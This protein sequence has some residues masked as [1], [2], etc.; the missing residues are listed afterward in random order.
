LRGEAGKQPVAPLVEFFRDGVV[1]GENVIVGS[2]VVICLIQV[3]RLLLAIFYH[4]RLI[5][6]NSQKSYGCDVQDWSALHL[7]C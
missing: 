2:A 7:L 4:Y 1:G 3:F 5:L 6:K